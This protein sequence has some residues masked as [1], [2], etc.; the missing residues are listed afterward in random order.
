MAQ[1]NVASLPFSNLP[2]LSNDQN[3]FN[4]NMPHAEQQ[5]LQQSVLTQQK[6]GGAIQK[7]MYQ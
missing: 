1:A 4:G 5:A 6:F 3:G 2:D 7:M